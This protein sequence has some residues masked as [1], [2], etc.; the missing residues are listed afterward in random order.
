MAVSAFLNSNERYARAQVAAAHNPSDNNSAAPKL[1]P[2]EPLSL[3]HLHHVSLTPLGRKAILGGDLA[4]E[5]RRLLIELAD[6][7]GYRLV[8]VSM[9]P[10]RLN[11]LLELNG[12]HRPESISREIKGLTGLRLMQS[13]PWLR[14]KLKANRLWE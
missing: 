14:G 4:S 6:H 12:L 8:S 7:G 2:V 3:D 10:D 1:M 11:V 5:L 9:A 13:F